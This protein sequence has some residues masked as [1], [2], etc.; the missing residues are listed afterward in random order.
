MNAT[1]TYLA[2]LAK[3]F[4]D[5]SSSEMSYRTALQNYLATIFPAPEFVIQH[6]PRTVGGNKPDYIVRRGD[7]PLLYIEVKDPRKPGSDLDKI[8]KSDQATRYFGYTNLII[9]DYAEFR[10][11]RNGERYDEPVLLATLDKRTHRLEPHPERGDSFA[12]IVQN[13][14]ASQKEPIRK[15]SH[16]AK[17]MGGRAQRI[18]D[19]VLALLENESEAR[20][21]LEA[22]MRFIKEHLISNFGPD[23]FADMYA[24]TIVYGLFAARYHDHSRDTFSR[25]EA[26]ALVPKSNP[27]LRQFFGH[28]AGPSFPKRLEII[29]DELC[30]VFTH[31]SVK[32]LMEEYFKQ[33][34]LDGGEVESPD[35]VIHFY[36]DFLREYNS[37]KKMEMGVFYTPLPVVRFIVRGV[38][39]LL[40]KE[41]GIERGLSD[42]QKTTVEKVGVGKNGKPV[43]DLIEVHR[44]QILDVATGTGTFLNETIKHIYDASSAIHGRWTSYVE[45]HVLPRLHGF[46]LMMASYTIAHL[47]LGM[48][49]AREGVLEF[50]NRL[51]VYL[52]N[53]LDDAHHIPFT[54]SLFG[55]VESIAQESRLASEVKR[56]HPIMVVMGN[57]PYS[58]ES[59]NPHYTD[60]DVYKVE[61]GGEEKLKEK[62]SKWINDDYVKFIRFGESMVEKNGEGIIAMITAHGY[63]DNPTFRGMRW[64]LRKTFDVIYVLDLHGNS[65][66]KE[67]APDGST[68]QNV[69]DIKTGV[70]IIF[71]VKKRHEDGEA[72]PLATVHTA[73]LYGS[74]RGKFEALSGATTMEH[75]KWTTLPASADVWKVEG[76]GKGEYQT[77]F[78]VAELFQVNS[79]GIVT[80]RDNM[81]I[82]PTHADIEWVLEDFRTLTVEDLRQ[83]YKLGKDVRDWSVAGAQADVRKDDGV[84][85]SV[86]YRPFD[87]RYT[88]FTGRSK[89]FHCMPRS[90]VMKNFLAGENVGLV[91]S[92]QVLGSYNWNDVFII[93]KI[94]EF[95]IMATRVSNSA[96]VMPL[97]LYTDTGEK[98]PNLDRTIVKQIETIVG[99]TTPEDILD[100]VYAAL[101][102][103]SYRTTYGEFL[104]SDFPR[105]PYPKSE[106]VFFALVA[107]GRHLR[108]LHLLTHPAVRKPITTF[109]ER[110]SDE[111]AKP[112]Y[113][114]G[115][116][117]I[118]DTQYWEGVTKEVWEFYIG[119]YQ[120]AQKYLK[121]R[122]GRKLSADECDNYEKMIV[123]LAETIKVMNEIDTIKFF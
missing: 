94:T 100:Y 8:E 20:T 123:A 117:Y 99:I 98:V 114:N 90:E 102:S 95:G 71:G 121:D 50:K 29:V 74:R 92:R 36:E 77:G 84:I 64:H 79:V 19:N 80:A 35:P 33:G 49:L 39:T 13:F 69:F 116:V 6:D 66:K 15:G 81:S 34:T 86:S 73:D 60:N 18:R 101:H 10:F 1:V 54:N 3:Y 45:D 72:K 17:I 109:P 43:T 96:P 22:M 42:N 70:S 119:G 52:T 67:T 14:V 9:S 105:V 62:N 106:E 32:E 82:Q 88:Y 47:K 65:N 58:G 53:T 75:L 16:L 85:T 111:V 107:H 31:A 104:K 108:E 103:P 30:E 37:A 41:F 89:G 51:G 78:S 63:I 11:Y 26:Q 118:N 113:R 25:L 23:E 2:E 55:V 83:K 21:D 7:V 93:N 120:P 28:I 38:D 4:V 12:R 112:E 115:R 97:Y 24:Q 61:P 48:T 87:T 5:D 57:P 46:E 91:A 110:G 44:V 59:Q 68:D 56:E 76:E 27:F 40:K 122:K